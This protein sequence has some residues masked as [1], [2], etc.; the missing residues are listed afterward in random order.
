MRKPNS[1]PKL[2]GH[3]QRDTDR[4]GAQTLHHLRT[5]KPLLLRGNP[6]SSYAEMLS[7]AV[8]P[9]TTSKQSEL[10]EGRLRWLMGGGVRRSS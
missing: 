3:F 7:R 2:L 5:N 9:D 4:R 1:S 10:E 6:H 8:I